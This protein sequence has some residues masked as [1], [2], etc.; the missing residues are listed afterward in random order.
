MRAAADHTT[1]PNPQGS[2]FVG[3]VLAI[4]IF[5]ALAAAL[6]SLHA[7]ASRSRAG[8][9][10]AQRAYFLA[11]SGFRY[12]DQQV[13]QHASDTASDKELKD[14]SDITRPGDS[15]RD[16]VEG[17]KLVNPSERI[18]LGLYPHYL[19]TTQDTTGVQLKASTMGDIV[20]ADRLLSFPANG[21]L[22]IISNDEQVTIQDI[23]SY[24]SVSR[25]DETYTFS[26]LSP[27]VTNLPAGSLVLPAARVSG[28]Q[29]VLPGGALNLVANSAQAFPTRNGSL[30]IGG[31][32]Y[33]YDRYDPAANQLLG[34]TELANPPV[35]LL[36]TGGEALALN[37]VLA[38]ESVGVFD[39]GVDPAR[40]RIHYTIAMA[41]PLRKI[42]IDSDFGAT[43][44]TSGFTN[45]EDPSLGTYQVVDTD[46]GPGTEKALQVTA[47]TTTASGEASL[48]A[49][50]DSDN[51]VSL[52]SSRR[53]ND[54]YLSYDAQV[55]VGFA[56][57]TPPAGAPA[58]YMAG[59]NFRLKSTAADA[60]SYGVSIVKAAAGDE[61]PDGFIPTVG[62]GTFPSDTTPLV[63][64][65]LILLWEQT[66]NATTQQWLSCAVAYGGP[67]YY[68][69]DWEL[70]VARL[71]SHRTDALW[72]L[73]SRRAD[74]NG[75]MQPRRCTT[76]GRGGR[77][78]STSAPPTTALFFT[79]TVNRLVRGQQRSADLLVLAPD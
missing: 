48:I 44:A 56:G 2:V 31:S 17:I 11:E 15:E 62:T 65:P 29:T 4:V 43:G 30:E 5:A 26:G 20:P 25:T 74:R 21:R 3:L 75:T 41:T 59:L 51:L 71:V 77:G 18:E 79:S 73:S 60:D 64:I 14:L 67:S 52:Q 69:Q 72:H 27:T 58:D 1:Q 45:F 68:E 37:R 13:T 57:Y 12:V 23:F 49:Y 35:S 50:K 24:T 42:G 63:G 66:G 55:K 19:R 40:K 78:T 22:K 36:F 10:N 46:P 53:Y 34:V 7:T 38:L 9:A 6:V 70:G 61:I 39:P 32:F 33:G 8:A 47:T 28:P 16:L 76:A 54:R